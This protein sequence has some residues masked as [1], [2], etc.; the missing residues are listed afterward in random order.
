MAAAPP[1]VERIDQCG[2][3][4]LGRLGRSGFSKQ[5]QQLV[6]PKQSYV[7]SEGS[8]SVWNQKPP[9]AKRDEHDSGRPP[10]HPG[11]LEAPWTGYEGWNDEKLCAS[12]H[13]R[14]IL[15]PYPPQALTA[16]WCSLL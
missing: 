16:Q 10:T 7:M 8:G 5:P 15:Y 2:A 4:L 3:V 9:R 6:S 12:R 11:S 1:C 14:K 13:A